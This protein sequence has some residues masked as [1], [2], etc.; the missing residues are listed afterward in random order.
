MRRALRLTTY[1]LLGGLLALTLAATLHLR[2]QRPVRDGSLALPGLKAPVTVRYDEAGVPHVKAEHEADLYRALGYLH[3]QDRL[4]QME[5]LRRL[6]RGEL[7]EVL[8]PN[9]VGTDRLFRTLGIRH[10]ADQQATGID[11]RQPAHAALLAYLDGVNHF[12]ASGPVP[13]EFELLGMPRRPFT[14][15]D[16]YSV[17]GYL[18]YSFASALR[19]EPVMTQLRDRLGPAYLKIFTPDGQTPPARPR[20]LPPP[21]LA[22]ADLAALG[23]L[24]QLSLSPMELAGLPQLEG[25]NAWAIAGRRTASG[26][27][28]LAGDPHIGYAVPAVWWEAHLEAPGFSLYGHFTAL[29]PMALLGHS[30]RHAW[31]LT[32]FQNDDMDLVAERT[33]ALHPGRVWFEGRWVPLAERQE[34]VQVKGGE[35]VVLTLR[36][37]PHGPL[38]ND[39]LPPE[40]AP[41]TPI[42]LWWTLLETDNP[43]LESF[44]RLNRADTL[45]E[46]RGAAQGV[47]APGLNIVWANAAGDIGWWAAA[48]LPRRPA[49]VD[50]AFILDAAQGEADK[51]GFLPFSANPQEENPARGYLVSANQAPAGHAVAGYYAIHD[52]VERL[53]RSLRER[54]TGWTAEHAAAL[55]HADDTRYPQRLMAPLLQAL[56]DRP[57]PDED[58]R[59][60]D[61]LAGW[62]GQHS[63]DRIEPT[64]Y[65]QWVHELLRL[66]LADEVGPTL[67]PHLL[68][69]RALDDALP[70]L[71]ADPASPWWDRRDTPAQETR[72]D[73]ALA[74]WQAALAHL[75]QQWGPDPGGWTWGRAHT[76]THPH[77]L[78]RQKPLDRLFNVGPL[79]VPGGREMPNNQA[80]ALGPAPWAVTYG[81][82]TRRVIDLG[83]PGQA[84]GINPVGQS[85]VWGDRHYADQAARHAANQAR[86]QWLDEADVAAHTVS[87]LQMKPAH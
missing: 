47:H 6:A 25:S 22:A 62:P 49:G 27:P 21:R 18:A 14:P 82:S 41:A 65:H 12:V 87:T 20:A 16:T 71:T 55:Q 68:K 46:A 24:A 43:L 73:I 36:Q 1:T 26:K 86:P 8:G 44:Y 3:A 33:D 13:L 9:L 42:A 85:G 60:L 59:L 54:E 2:G 51:P 76:L 5:M 75:R 45:A 28:L 72:E 19:T 84:Q 52:R 37:S 23:R 58:R 74:A 38:I 67:F 32:M 78:G 29:N 61:L 34:T 77:P 81:P 7:A 31:S 56:R 64:L 15:A 35:P 17:A 70:R 48:H 11:P 63:L 53:E 50:P 69:M 80:F 30:A 57:L 66:A 10:H 39:A 83:A 4:F 40:L 79:P